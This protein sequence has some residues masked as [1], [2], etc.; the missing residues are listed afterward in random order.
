M[1]VTMLEKCQITVYL[2]RTM[3]I[4]P[5]LVKAWKKCQQHSHILP[6]IGDTIKEVLFFI[7]LIKTN[8][9]VKPDLRHIP[10]HLLNPAFHQL[11]FA[12]IYDELRGPSSEMEAEFQQETREENNF[13]ENEIIDIESVSDDEI[14]MVIDVTDDNVETKM[15]DE[16][17]EEETEEEKEIEIE[18]ED[19]DAWEQ[20]PPAEG[21]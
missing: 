6:N 11:V 18:H 19:E 3:P 16:E 8:V 2:A 1:L 12:P 9:D 10:E 21:G 4:I 5:A 17:E 20:V 15:E 7:T 14:S 13:E